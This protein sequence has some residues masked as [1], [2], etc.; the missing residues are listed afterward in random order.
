MIIPERRMVAGMDADVLSVRL[1]RADR[2]GLD[3]QLISVNEE[4]PG[5]AMLVSGH[6]GLIHP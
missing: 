4:N 6:F 1:G 3:E 2:C 5:L